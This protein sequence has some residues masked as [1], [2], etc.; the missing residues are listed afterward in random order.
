MKKS[1]TLRFQRTLCTKLAGER[2]TLRICRRAA[3]SV[4]CTW[5]YF[6]IIGE[7]TPISTFELWHAQHCRDPKLAQSKHES[8]PRRSDCHVIAYF[9]SR[10]NVSPRL[11]LSCGKSHA[12]Q[13]PRT[14][15]PCC[16]LKRTKSLG[17]ASSSIFAS[18]A[19]MIVE[20]TWSRVESSGLPTAIFAKYVTDSAFNHSDL[21][22]QVH[23]A[24]SITWYTYELFAFIRLLHC[25]L[26][27]HRR[28][29]SS[30]H[31]HNTVYSPSSFTEGCSAT[32][33]FQI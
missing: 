17:S 5:T 11:V 27:G 2:L 16:R 7:N 15:K 26:M 1:P 9:C 32:L 30:N 14:R 13:L 24:F 8:I 23:S 19:V 21:R 10:D 29:L 33:L 28:C 31:R 6:N 4:A 22:F 25:G 3:L 18:N 12:E 20:R